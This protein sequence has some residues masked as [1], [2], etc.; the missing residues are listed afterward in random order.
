MSNELSKQTTPDT[1]TDK[2]VDVE[3]ESASI[4]AS[5]PEPAQPNPTQFH[6][7][8]IFIDAVEHAQRR[9]AFVLAEA[10]L[11]AQA[12][13]VTRQSVSTLRSPF[14]ILHKNLR[15]Q[16]AAAPAAASAAASAAAPAA[17]SAAASAAAPEE[18]SLE[19][20]PEESSKP[21]EST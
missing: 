5:V 12:V 19:S 1:T 9:G 4:P 8:E 14:A 13:R 3:Q 7:I 17:A 6:P 18:T 11:I 15:D 21:T 10:E 16:Q 20:I 2:V